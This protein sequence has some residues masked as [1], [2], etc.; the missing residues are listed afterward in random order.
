[1]IVV[2]R[3]EPALHATAWRF[4]CR[5]GFDRS[6]VTP[7]VLSGPGAVVAR[8]SV[9]M[10]ESSRSSTPTSPHPTDFVGDADLATRQEILDADERLRLPIGCFLVRSGERLVLIDAGVGPVHDEMLDGGR[11]LDALPASVQGRA[12]ST[13]QPALHCR[14]MEA[15]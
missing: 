1:L 9:V 12:I 15:R 3:L 4:E 13:E 2:E 8:G 7:S 11:L 5:A 10:C 14:V 6:K